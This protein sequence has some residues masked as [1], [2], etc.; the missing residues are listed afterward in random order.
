MSTEH[1]SANLPCIISSQ[2]RKFAVDLRFKAIREP[3]LGAFS[4]FYGK[5]HAIVLHSVKLA[6]DILL[7]VSSMYHPSLLMYKFRLR[8]EQKVVS[9]LFLLV[10]EREWHYITHFY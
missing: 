1:V 7:T 3:H 4:P 8:T 6:I 9:F 2:I 10:W 5:V